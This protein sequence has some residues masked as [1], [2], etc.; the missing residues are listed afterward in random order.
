MTLGRMFTRNDVT[1]LQLL[2]F[3]LSEHLFISYISVDSRY[4]RYIRLQ[5]PHKEGMDDKDALVKAE[6]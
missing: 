4:S 3:C 1:E 5:F 6:Q 2:S